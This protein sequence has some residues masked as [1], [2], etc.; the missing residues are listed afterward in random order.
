MVLDVN[1]SMTGKMIELQG[2]VA[3]LCDKT[4][5][6]LVSTHIPPSSKLQLCIGLPIAHGQD[7]S[8]FQAS[9]EVSSLPYQ[10]LQLDMFKPACS[11]SNP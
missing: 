4:P 10:M 7:V 2:C 3:C 1:A 11:N 6:H 8:V 5:T 9:R